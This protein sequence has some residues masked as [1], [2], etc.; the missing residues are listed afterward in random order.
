M[1]QS[2]TVLASAHETHPGNRDIL[3]A[4]ATFNEKK[5]NLTAAAQYA[6]KLVALSPNDPGAYQLLQRIKSRTP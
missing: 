5:G 1:D 4:L 6:E 3:A 2:L